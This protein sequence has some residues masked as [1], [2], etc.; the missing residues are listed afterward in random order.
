MVVVELTVPGVPIGQP[1]QRHTLSG[2]NYLPKDHPVNAFKAG[3]R[4]AW[5]NSGGHPINGACHVRILAVFPRPARLIWK[6][7]PMLQQPHAAK[8]DADNVAKA[9][10]DALTN[11]AWKDDSIVSDL[12]VHK[13]IAAGGE[14]PHVLVEITELNEGV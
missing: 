10:L 7:R 3:L 14:Q 8:P 2:R 5:A 4:L 6:T 9:V 11:L 1:R 13:R 12:T